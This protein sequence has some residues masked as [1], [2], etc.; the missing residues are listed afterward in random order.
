MSRR[1]IVLL[2]SKVVCSLGCHHHH[3]HYPSSCWD[4]VQSCIFCQSDKIP[5]GSVYTTL[6]VWLV[7][8][9]RSEVLDRV[10]VGC[11]T[12][13]ARALGPQ[14][15]LILQVMIRQMQIPLR[16]R[17]HCASMSLHEMFVVQPLAQTLLRSQSHSASMILYG[18]L[19]VRLSVLAV[20]RVLSV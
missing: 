20:A 14:N 17:D 7:R 6:C 16:L 18:W 2:D 13:W 15:H 9:V 12:W 5:F 3:S 10:G 11:P 1:K 8:T 4:H 19:P